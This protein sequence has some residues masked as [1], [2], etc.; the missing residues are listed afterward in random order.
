MVPTA[1]VGS[2]HSLLLPTTLFW[3]PTTLCWLLPLLAKRVVVLRTCSFFAL[4]TRQVDNCVRCSQA[5]CAVGEGHLLTLLERHGRLR[6][7]RCCLRW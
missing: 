5:A 3:F 7:G 4:L 1:F 6:W 2:Y